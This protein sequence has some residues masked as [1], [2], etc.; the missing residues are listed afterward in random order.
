MRENLFAFDCGSTNWRLYRVT[1][2]AERQAVRML[3]EPQPSP[4]T[5]FVEQRLPTVILLSPEGDRLQSFGEAAYQYLYDERLRDYIRDFFKPSIGAHLLRRPLPHQTRYTHQEALDYTKLLLKAVL[6]QLKAEKWRSRPF[7]ETIRF[8]FT[9]PVHWRDDYNGQIFDEFKQLV[10]DCLP[11]YFE[12][13]ISFVSEPEAAIL[14][15]QR[16]GLLDLAGGV[17]L[18]IDSGGST[19]D[20]TAGNLNARGQLEGVHRY[21]EPHGGGLYDDELATY[22][23]EELKIPAHELANDP[24]A[25]HLLRMFGR[26]LKEALSRQLLVP[27]QFTQMPQR[28][29]TVVLQN[30]QVYRKTIRLTED[31]F[32]LVTRHLQSDF[33]YL[34]TNGLRT[35]RLREEDVRQVALVGGSAQL[36]TNVRQLRQRFG[37]AKIVL[38]DNPSETV[39]HGL[40]LEYGHAF[41]TDQPWLRSEYTLFEQRRT[42]AGPQPSASPQIQANV[43][44]DATMVEDDPARLQVADPPPV[45]K[46]KTENGQIYP[47]DA[48]RITIGRKRTSEIVIYDDQASR[49]HACIQVNSAGC[50]IMDLGSSNGT[51]VNGI[52]LSP[53]QNKILQENDQIRI[54]RTIYTYCK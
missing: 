17:V 49:S 26:Q 3:G 13:Q 19:T 50:E 38:A 39:V 43:D 46:L 31:V 52:R 7:D 54:G 33:N 15:L 25:R 22:I 27:S 42:A 24:S 53:K 1:Y 12:N 41:G 36:F 6:E 8:A 28:A 2:E 40:A 5:S 45:W 9:Y 48:P 30:G 35:M 14:S 18:L 29:I 21:G 47:L 37:E 23:A 51:F 4:L 11:P 20:L 34:I 10:L 44:E 32:N 16:Q